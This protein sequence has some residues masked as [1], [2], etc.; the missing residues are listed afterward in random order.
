MR[1]ATANV[2]PRCMYLMLVLLLLPADVYSHV[3]H[4][5]ME[6][7]HE[8]QRAHDQP[9]Y[10]RSIVRDVATLTIQFR[11]GDFSHGRR[12]TDGNL[13]LSNGLNA[14]PIAYSGKHVNYANGGRSNIQFHKSPDGA[15]VFKKPNGGWY[16]VS[17]A[18]NETVGINWWNGGVGSIEF[19]SK[20]RIVGYKRVANRM[21]KNCSGGKTP[22]NSWVTCEEIENGKVYQV[23]PIGVK[24]P[25]MTSMGT[26]GFY[27]SFAFDVRKD[28]ARPTFYVTC[29]SNRGSLTRF[30]PN[31]RGMQCFNKPNNYDRWCT[32]NHGTLDYLLISGGPKGTFR[33][34]TN[35][36]AARNNAELYYPNSEGIDI[37]DGM[38]YTT[39]K[40]LKRLMILNLRNMTYTYTSTMSGAFNEQPDQVARLLK[41]TSHSILYFCEDGGL[42]ATSPGVF[43]RSPNGKYF[44][45]LRGSFP[46][47][48]ETTGLAFSPDGHHMYVAYQNVGIIYDV[49]RVDGLK[50][51]GAVLDIKYH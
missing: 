43:G 22:W 42:G 28:A 18:E 25:N 51:S 13:Y 9:S 46:Q 32:L 39:S 17:N 23:D 20:G 7:D 36:G 3:I 5:N 45:I 41:G 26:L 37:V 33:W 31:V 38:L 21:R 47:K 12:S 44:T 50:F 4:S 48:D 14:K 27:E 49:W 30:T 19:D 11:P 24:T 40:K 34:T 35:E 1:T 10:N 16:Y 2:L 15:A 8:S 6:F 29:D